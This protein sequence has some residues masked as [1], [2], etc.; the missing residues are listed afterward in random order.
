MHAAGCFRAWAE[1]RE[2]ESAV[3]RV[4]GNG[5]RLMGPL[6]QGSA[7]KGPPLGWTVGTVWAK[8]SMLNGP[9]SGT[10]DCHVTAVL[11]LAVLAK[12]SADTRQEHLSASALWIEG[13]LTTN[14]ILSSTE[15]HLRVCPIRKCVAFLIM[16]IYKL[17]NTYRRLCARFLHEGSKG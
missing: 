6:R 17:S 9:S 3:D 7:R 2:K 12:E 14:L 4:S 1:C 13:P 11:R 5:C 15:Q 10:P 8:K 16:I